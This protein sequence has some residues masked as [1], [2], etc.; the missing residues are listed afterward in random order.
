MPKR[1][2]IFLASW[3]ALGL[4]Q[5]AWAEDVQVAVAAN[6]AP[7]M[8]AIAA[9]FEKSTGHK[10]FLAFGSTGKFHA[11][12][13]NGAPFDVFLA[14]DAATPAKLEREGAALPG[15]RFTYAIGKLVLWSAKPNFVD[16]TGEILKSGSFNR[17]ALAAP[18]LSPY[19]AAAIEALENLGLKD[20]LRPKFVQGENIAQVYQFVATGNADLGFV[21]LSQVYRDGKLGAGSG[22]IVPANLHAPIRQDA[23]ILSR[24]GNNPA[25]LSLAEFLKGEKARAIV[26][27]H[28]Y[29]Y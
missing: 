22:W 19:G 2:S 1:P 8:K 27:S 18:K 4:A 25:A 26:T 3:F 23:V 11:Q 5:P 24:A 13:V 29:D 20:A 9:A 14:A 15:S 10:A 17:V 12:I 21:A 16:A 6:F 7:P 28:G